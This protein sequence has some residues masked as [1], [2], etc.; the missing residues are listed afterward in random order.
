MKALTRR[1]GG[2]FHHR[3]NS[4][5]CRRC[6]SARPRR[7]CCSTCPLCIKGRGMLPKGRGTLPKGRGTLPKGRD[8]LPKGQGGGPLFFGGGPLFCAQNNGPPPKKKGPPPR[9]S[10]GQSVGQIG[11]RGQNHKKRVMILEEGA[12]AEDRRSAH[13]TTQRPALLSFAFPS[14][15]GGARC[16]EAGSAVRAA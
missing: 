12:L 9:Q 2:A 14:R 4:R 7:R 6:C 13:C 5:S 11:G 15:R 8:M 16:T 10:A 1:A 3:R